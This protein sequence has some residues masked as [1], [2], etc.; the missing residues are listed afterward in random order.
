[1]GTGVLDYFFFFLP[2]T[3]LIHRNNR[4]RRSDFDQHFRQ[5]LRMN[6]IARDSRTKIRAL[7]DVEQT[8]GAYSTFPL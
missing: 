5:V 3:C 4:R 2:Q 7:T 6:M 1:M 8:K